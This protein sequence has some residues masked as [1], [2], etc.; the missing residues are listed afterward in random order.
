M[1]YLDNAATTVPKPAAVC[2]AVAEAMEKNGN[3]AR[4]AHREALAALRV[5][6]AAREAVSARFGVGDP[7]RVVFTSGATMALSIAIG[8]VDGD[9]DGRIVCTAADHNSVL[10]PLHRRGGYEIVPVDR[11]GRPDMAGLRSAVE[12]GARAVVMTHASNVCGNVFDIEAAGEICRRRGIP[13][14]LDAAQSAGL[15]DVDMGALGVSALCFSGHKS[16]YAP[17]GIGCLCLA[18]GFVPPPLFVGGSGGDSFSP[19]P[20]EELPDALEAGT[21][22][23]HG[24]AGL[25]AGLAY[26]DGLGGAAFS[27]ADGLA[28]DFVEKV[29]ALGGVELYGDYDAAVRL[30]IVAL[31]LPGVDAAAAADALDERY[32]IAVRAGAHCAPLLHR[33]FGTERRG[34]VRFSFAHTNTGG[35]VDLAV[36]ALR[37]IMA[38]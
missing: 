29:R 22:N 37:E 12:G 13:F 32:G 19:D 2:R 35:D 34:A 5:V 10:R 31:N 27:R 28:R 14:I 21:V 4:G 33:A 3:A 17:Q 18:P 25:L 6:S 26:V 15:L 24:A 11:L 7:G 8:G 23:A 20:P 30:P 38:R 9:R 36:R 16:L 1:P